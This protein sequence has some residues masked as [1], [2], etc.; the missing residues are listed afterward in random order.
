MVEADF[1]HTT[2]HAFNLRLKGWQ[3]QQDRLEKERWE[4]AR[5]VAYNA[6]MAV[7]PYL[8]KNQRPSTPADMMRFPW[9]KAPA[10]VELPTGPDDSLKRYKMKLMRWKQGKRAIFNDDY[11]ALMRQHWTPDWGPHPDILATPKAQ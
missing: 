9:D 1:W 8:P 7:W 2:L 4:Q 10:P 11:E 5:I 6:Q 3:E